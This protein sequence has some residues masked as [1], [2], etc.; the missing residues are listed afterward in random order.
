MRK[1][2]NL[3]LLLSAFLLDQ[4]SFGKAEHVFEIAKQQVKKNFQGSLEFINHFEDGI[5]KEIFLNKKITNQDFNQ[6]A[7]ILKASQDLIAANNERINGGKRIFTCKD[8][9][10][11]Y[12]GPQ[13]VLHFF[14]VEVGQLDSRNQTRTSIKGN[15]FRDITFQYVH[16]MVGDQIKQ[17]KII[18]EAKNPKGLFCKDW[19]L[20]AHQE[21]YH[22]E[23][24][25]MKGKHEFVFNNLNKDARQ[26][27]DVNKIRIYQFC[28]DYQD[29]F[30]SIFHTLEL[31]IGALTMHK[32][33]PKPFNMVIPDY[34]INAN[35]DFLKHSMEYDMP[36][37]GY[38]QIE[39]K[40]EDVK[41]GDVFGI[42]RL[43]GLDPIIMY[44]A[45]GTIG[46]CAIAVSFNDEIYMIEVQ[47]AW[48]WPKATV[49]KNKLQ[50]WIRY[51]KDAQYHVSHFRLNKLARSM[52]NNTKAQEFFNQTEGIAYGFHNFLF[53]WLDTPN[54]NN[55][56]VL[57]PGMLANTFS[58]VET[59]SPE[60]VDIFMNQALNK[61]LGTKGLTLS[62]ISVEAAKRNLTLDDVI[63]MP[64]LDGWEYE[65]LEPKDGRSYVCSTYVTA[66]MKAAGV[67]G[68]MIFNPGEQTPRD[69]YQLTIFE[70][71]ST[72]RSKKCQETEPNTPWCQILGAYKMSFPG[73]STVKPYPHMNE[74]CPSI[75]PKYERTEG[76]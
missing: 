70:T 24:I 1:G 9:E 60:V 32:D 33:W 28:D 6:Q 17:V 56:P 54:D 69:M 12:G 61:R 51:A 40:E 58:L 21:F 41:P 37:R 7:D 68:D 65:G 29:T 23:T 52:F 13:D 39:V 31:F 35:L 5:R 50:D 15:C 62:Q 34:M 8:K 53:A 20:I 76:C 42:M 4:T 66:V 36:P 47:D 49:Q 3:L 25:F 38:D 73:F 30:M 46:H 43:D 14:P 71:T 22:F 72:W 2:L 75:A 63:A 45:G 18:I 74:R 44:G 11:A 19:F 26:S 48:Y 27:I 16:Y 67:F 55:P 57:P 10:R 64:E 59:I